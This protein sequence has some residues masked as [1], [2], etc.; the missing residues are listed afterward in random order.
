MP[1]Q[2]YQ[3]PEV[4]PTGKREKLWKVEYREYYLDP[5]GKEHSRHKSKTWPRA[6]FTKSQAQAA[7]DKFL[8]EVQAGG[9]KPDGLMTLEQ[10][11]RDIYL[12]I[13]ARHW[14]GYT[15]NLAASVWKC[16]IAPAFGKMA[17]KDITKA[18]VQIFL[19]RMADAGLGQKYVEGVLVRL[20]SIFEEALDND[21]V[22]K[23]PCRKVEVPPCKPPAE[24]RSLTEAEVRALW[25]G[26]EGRDYLFWRLMI[27]TGARISEVLPLER[28][29]LAQNERPPGS[30]GEAVEV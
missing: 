3:R 2:K 20:H 11:W 16:Y 12:P 14:T 15:P 18:G 19:G 28:A 24:A 17:L 4:Y 30:A 10:F 8:A 5:E 26:T 29:D 25:D 13:R 21:M 6:D 9:A 22:S 1:R 27:L 23:N 7:C